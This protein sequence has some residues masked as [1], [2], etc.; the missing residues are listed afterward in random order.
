MSHILDRPIWSALETAHAS[1]AEGGPLARRYPPSIVPFAASADNS[2]E[3]LQALAKLP[4]GEEVMA[5]VEAEPIIVPEGL[6]TLSSATLVQMIA[7][8]PSERISDR[9][10]EPLTETDAADMLALATL[11]KPGPFTLRAQSLGSFWGVKIDGRLVAMAGQ[12]MRQTGFAEL[13]GLCTHPDFQ[14]RGL[15]TLLFRFVAGEIAARGETAYLHA[16]TTNAPAIALYEAMGFRL[17]SEM[18]LCVVKRRA[19]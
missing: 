1:L 12:R 4:L 5:I 18:N 8:R 10:I 17:R 9:R 14:G 15:G 7:Q 13:S 3:S 16:Y 19:V 2:T 11:T 6:V